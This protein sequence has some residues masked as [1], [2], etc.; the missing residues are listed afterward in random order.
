MTAKIVS[1]VEKKPKVAKPP[2]PVKAQKAKKAAKAPAARGTPKKPWRPMDAETVREK[3]GQSI[4][5][6]SKPVNTNAWATG[7]R[8]AS[9]VKVD[10]PYVS[11]TTS[12]LNRRL[13]D[14]IIG[15][16]PAARP[17]NQSASI[18]EGAENQVYEGCTDEQKSMVIEQS[19]CLD[20]AFDCG[21][22]RVDARL[23]QVIFPDRDEHGP[24]ALTPLHSSVFSL[25]I[26]KRLNTEFEA[27]QA[28]KDPSHRD[29]GRKKAVLKVGGENP[30]NLGRHIHAMLRPLVFTAP[31]ESA[32]VKR[33]FGIFHRGMDLRRA[34]RRDDLLKLYAWRE[35]HKDKQGNMTTSAALRKQEA[36][37]IKAAVLGA[38]QECTL[39]TQFLDGHAKI[40]GARA[41]DAVPQSSQALIDPEMRTRQWAAEFAR[42][43][44]IVIEE[45]APHKKSAAMASHGDLNSLLKTIEEVVS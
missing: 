5:Y 14:Y 6:S 40:L 43:M 9:D 32:S 19:V 44:L 36:D 16:A 27:Q 13:T 30:Q 17:F 20:R 23:R 35:E 41:S 18:I 3:L 22:D 38:L 15:G 7:V 2:K 31:I 1:R 42:E 10:L 33:A 29:F 8:V 28:I 45:F 39:T 37:L 4:H 25:E 24:V 11:F 21:T 26:K 34:V 12:R